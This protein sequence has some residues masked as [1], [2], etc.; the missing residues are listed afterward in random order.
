M[1]TN[2]LIVLPIFALILTG[3]IAR[4]TDA[5]GPN[6][7]REVN[8]LVVYLA[9]P[10]LLFDI[11]ANAKLSQIWQPGFILAFTAGCAIIF[12]A[13]LWWRM[14]KGRHLADAAIDSLNASY[15]NTGFV[16]F[17]LVLSIVGDNGMAPTLIATIV[18]V[19][20]L[21]AVAI[22]LIEGGL[23][24][25]TRR[26]DIAMK[27]LLSLAKNPLLIAPV[28]GALFMVSGVALPAPVHAFLKLLGGAASPCALIALGLFLAGSKAGAATERAATAGILVGLKLIAQPAVTWL[29]A[30]P[31]LK[32]PPVAVHTCVLLAALPTGTGPFMLAEFYGREASLTGRVVL[33]STVL[34]IATIS[35][36]LVIAGA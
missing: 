10:A 25:E 2:L 21:F 35:A 26:R 15:A 34:S 32:L 30:G 36:Y 12:C 4:K 22:V 27:T 13:T 6:A 24:S 3:W 5:L 33:A 16:G 28:M 14:A 20:V 18:T 9:L 31:I 7:T 8:R 29:I 11:M 17:P 19:C 1:L 23:Q